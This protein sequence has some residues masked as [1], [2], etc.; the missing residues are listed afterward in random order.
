MDFDQNLRGILIR[1][2]TVDFDEK[3]WILI[4]ILKEIRKR[5]VEI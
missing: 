3:I 4:R 2:T 1:K 5:N